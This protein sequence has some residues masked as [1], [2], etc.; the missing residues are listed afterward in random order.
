MAFDAVKVK[1]QLENAFCNNSEVELLEIL[2]QNSFLFH[3]L[4]DRKFSIQPNFSEVPFGSKFRCDFCWLNDNSDGPEWVLVEIEKPN[5]RLFNKSG[6][7]SSELNHA[8]EQVTSWDRYFQS[9]PAEKSRIFGAV[10]RFRFLLVAGRREY[11]QAKHAAQ[12][13]RFHNN[14]SNIEIHS[15]DVIF[16]ALGHY[17]KYKNSFSSFEENPISLKAK[18]LEKNW[19]DY[20]Y[21]GHWRSH[22][23]YSHSC[24]MAVCQMVAL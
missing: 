12:W 21:I 17:S 3:S 18:E 24:A 9:Y 23:K 5:M 7:P 14:N 1:A 15:S 6:D 11:W 10:N 4:Y 8:I 2:K 19:S 20:P 22:H 13:R 16:D